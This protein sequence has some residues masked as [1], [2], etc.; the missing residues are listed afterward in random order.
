MDFHH[1]DGNTKYNDRTYHD[2][3]NVDRSNEKPKERN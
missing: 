1:K 3:R 2:D